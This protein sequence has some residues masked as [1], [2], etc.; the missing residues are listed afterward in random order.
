MALEQSVEQFKSKARLPD[1]VIPKRYDLFLKPDLSSSCKFA[2][3][4]QIAVDVVAPTR[5]VVLNASD[6]AVQD[7]SVCFKKDSSSQV[8]LIP[9]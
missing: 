2:G 7:G 1:F 5:F 4:V 8:I 9:L 3:A 6:L